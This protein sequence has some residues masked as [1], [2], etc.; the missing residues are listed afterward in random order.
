MLQHLVESFSGSVEVIITA[1]KVG[2]YIRN[3]MFKNHILVSVVRCAQT[4]GRVY[5]SGFTETAVIKIDMWFVEN[6]YYKSPTDHHGSL[7]TAA[8]DLAALHTTI[9]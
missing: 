8:S 6:T 4:L 2:D 5:L 7:G 3:V 9:Y 1:K